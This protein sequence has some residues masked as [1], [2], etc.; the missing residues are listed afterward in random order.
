MQESRQLIEILER[1]NL[2]GFDKPGG[3]DKATD[4]SYTGV[5]EH[6][7]TPYKD[8]ESVNLLEIGVQLGGSSLLWQEF[9]PNANL[10]LADIHDSR[11][12]SIVEKLDKSRSR[13]Y[14]LDAYSDASRNFLL[15]ECQDGFDI[16]IDDGPHTLESQ[17][18]CIKNFLP[19]LRPGGFM[20]I[21]DL[22]SVDW[23]EHLN[24][25]VPLEYRESVEV[26]DL[27]GM[28]GRFDDL[29]FVIKK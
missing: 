20:I 13:F 21:E 25:Y 28:K 7:M 26:F 22:Q 15:R 17:I 18:L 27:R 10:Y 14:L 4:H 3:T 8:K 23:I 6:L 5:Y 29:L 19:L 12:Q 1:H 24:Q 9:L 11:H 2:N 16:I